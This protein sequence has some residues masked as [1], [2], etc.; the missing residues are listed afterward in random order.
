[1]CQLR[2][3]KQRAPLPG[4]AILQLPDNHRDTGPGPKLLAGQLQR[5]EK[6]H[7]GLWCHPEQMNTRPLGSTH[8]VARPLGETANITADSRGLSNSW[9]V[10]SKSLYLGRDSLKW[11]HSQ[12]TFPLMLR[13]KK[14]WQRWV[15]GCLWLGLEMGR[16]CKWAQGFS[17][18][19]GRVWKLV[20]VTQLCKYAKNHRMGHFKWVNCTVCKL[21]LNKAIFKISCMGADTHS[22]EI[23]LL[24]KLPPSTSDSNMPLLKIAPL[25]LPDHL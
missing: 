13:K 3:R 5:T 6:K 17:R 2:T 8:P 9:E 12:E 7:T 18:H 10:K 19:E 22:G 4:H 14:K 1:M 23:S 24:K 16:D 25:M 20:I 15:V 11:I 21:D